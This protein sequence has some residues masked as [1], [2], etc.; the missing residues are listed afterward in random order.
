MNLDGVL[1]SV[2]DDTV[3]VDRSSIVR[4]FVLDANGERPVDVLALIC[5]LGLEHSR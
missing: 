4:S 2:T 5:E 3:I 1:V